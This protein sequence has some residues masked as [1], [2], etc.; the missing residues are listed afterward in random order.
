MN[1]YAKYIAG[2]IVFPEEFSNMYFSHRYLSS[3]LWGRSPTSRC[4]Q[5]FRPQWP[6]DR[7]PCCRDQP[8]LLYTHKGH[9]VHSKV[10]QVHSKIIR[11]HSKVIRVHSKF[12][13]YIQRPPRT[14]KGHRVHSK[15]TTYIQ[16]HRVHSKVTAYIQRSS[17][18]HRKAIQFI[19]LSAHI[20]KIKMMAVYFVKSFITCPMSHMT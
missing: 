8:A 15:V 2:R 19:I 20:M 17:I 9:W 6:P 3:T 4:R 10:I 11:V 7:R 5:P 1:N 12:I 18:N 16:G 13:E 14:F